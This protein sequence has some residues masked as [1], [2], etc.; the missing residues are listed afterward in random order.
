MLRQLASWQASSHR[1]LA[2]LLYSACITPLVHFSLASLGIAWFAMTHPIMLDASNSSRMQMTLLSLPLTLS[3]CMRRSDM[4]S[5]TRKDCFSYAQNVDRVPSL[6]PRKPAHST[7]S[8]KKC[9]RR[10]KCSSSKAIA[11]RLFILGVGQE[12]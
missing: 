8:F 4:G 1:S 11:F 5:T 10:I 2:S 7:F 6:R 12:K 3:A 9:L